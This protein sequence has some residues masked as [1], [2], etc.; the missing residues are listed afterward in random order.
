VSKVLY[1]LHLLPD[2][3][4]TAEAALVP[5][6]IDGAAIRGSA[7][8]GRPSAVTAGIGD[9]RPPARIGDAASKPPSRNSRPIFAG[10]SW[11][12]STALRRE[13][14]ATFAK[15]F[16]RAEGSAAGGRGAEAPVWPWAAALLA[17][18][19]IAARARSCGP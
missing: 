16:P 4:D 2:R 5:V 12:A 6:E 7:V 17:V 1:E 9:A 3:R 18:S 11:P 10:S 14:S 13:S 8:A 15:S 19:A